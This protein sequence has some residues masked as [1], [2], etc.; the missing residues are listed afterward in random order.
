MSLFGLLRRLFAPAAKTARGRDAHRLD[1]SSPMPIAPRKTAARSGAGKHSERFLK[2]GGVLTGNDLISDLTDGANMVDGTLMHEHADDR[3]H[4][5][6]FMKK[7]CDQILKSPTGGMMPAP[8]YFR[9]VAILSRKKKNY[10]QEI[11][12][13]ENY[14]KIV[15]SV[16]QSKSDLRT[17][18]EFS[19]LQQ[20]MIEPFEKRLIKARQLHSARQ[21]PTGRAE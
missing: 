17:L 11:L 3:K 13:C 7:C 19:R 10:E 21:F 6:D 14:I 1:P 16:R 9:R 20:V 4:D 2:Q 18:N 12:Y 15:K 8:F 5:L